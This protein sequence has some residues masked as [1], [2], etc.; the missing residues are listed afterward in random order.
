MTTTRTQKTARRTAAVVSALALAA[1][2]LLAGCYSGQAATTN[3]QSAMNSGNGTQEQVGDIRIEN[4]TLVTGPG[5][6]KAGTVIMTIVNTGRVP[7]RLIG[8][9]VNG[10]PAY[11][12]PGFGD[13]M[14]GEAVNFGYDGT[15]WINAY[16]LDIAKCAYVPVTVQFERAG[17][18]NFTV[19]SVPPTGIYEGIAPNPLLAPIS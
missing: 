6:S 10:A 17:V 7:D 9:A 1:A 5:I 18:K 12:T 8:V 2:P 15:A 14:P 3:A 19:L 16:G 13:V 11:V 4:A